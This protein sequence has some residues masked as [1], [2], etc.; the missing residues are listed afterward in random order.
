MIKRIDI[1]GRYAVQQRTC[2]GCGKGFPATRSDKIYCTPSC[3]GRTKY[4][5]A[6]AHAVRE[7]VCVGCDSPFQTRKTHQT[8][9]TVSCRKK[10]EMGRYASM[11]ARSEIATGD[12]GAAM[13]MLVCAD[14]LMR[15]YHVFRSMS[16]SS[17]CDIVI[18]AGKVAVRIEV[19]KGQLS[20]SGLPRCKPLNPDRHDIMATV[21]A[22]RT[23]IYEPD[24]P[25]L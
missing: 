24:L 21:M 22:D 5:T 3:S 6:T 7:K 16:P 14:L 18:L 4:R 8:Y 10:A 15:G 13:E 1:I 2:V 17:P 19:K 23:I 12:V 20:A 25:T 11:N 9:C